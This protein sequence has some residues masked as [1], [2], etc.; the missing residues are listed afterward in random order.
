MLGDGSAE[1][2][3]ER[4]G[5]PA[6]AVWRA[7]FLRLKISLMIGV[8]NLASNERFVFFPFATTPQSP[9][10]RLFRHQTLFDGAAGSRRSKGW[11]PRP[12]ELAR[13]MPCRVS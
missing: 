11:R 13:H 8:T 2:K 12:G 1:Q 7:A 5:E 10:K 6:A 4:R 9:W 3:F